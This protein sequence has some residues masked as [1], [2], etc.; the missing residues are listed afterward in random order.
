MFIHTM[1]NAPTSCTLQCQKI[2]HPMLILEMIHYTTNLIINILTHKAIGQFMY[3]HIIQ[4][5]L[6]YGLSKY[7]LLGKT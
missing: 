1:K 3:S 2:K 7:I 5:V 4:H 6:I